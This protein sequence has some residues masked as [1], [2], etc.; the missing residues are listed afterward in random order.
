MSKKSNTY[1][2]HNWWME[3]KTSPELA[4]MAREIT[5]KSDLCLCSPVH[6]CEEGKY[7]EC[8]INSCII[9]GS[10]NVPD[11]P[12]AQKH[13]KPGQHYHWVGDDKS[14]PA[15]KQEGAEDD[16][17]HVLQHG[18]HRSLWPRDGPSRSLFNI[19]WSSWRP[20]CWGTFN[21]VNDLRQR[22][23]G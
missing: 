5:V 1:K 16:C 20:F 14:H 11:F 21:N 17:G 2:T 22:K 15:H 19:L 23:L 18:V 12:N 4:R 13:I 10:Y 7:L 9:S 3:K 8:V 6:I